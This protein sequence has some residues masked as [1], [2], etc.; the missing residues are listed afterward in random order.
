MGVANVRD[1]SVF[2]RIER[3]PR[4]IQGAAAISIRRELRSRRGVR[5]LSLLEVYR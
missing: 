1:R 4:L 3:R 2:E 5:M